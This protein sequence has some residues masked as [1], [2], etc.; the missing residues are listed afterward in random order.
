[1]QPAETLAS[2]HNLV[3]VSAPACA[4]LAFQQCVTASTGLTWVADTH[5]A[6]EEEKKKILNATLKHHQVK[7]RGTFINPFKEKG[8]QT[9]DLLPQ[10][11]KKKPAELL[12]YNEERII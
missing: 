2:P 10:W 11:I 8:N 6:A 4:V 1:M 3:P 7:R 12:R 5:E 9:P